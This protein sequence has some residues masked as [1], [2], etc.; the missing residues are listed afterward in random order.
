LRLSALVDNNGPRHPPSPSVF[1]K[2]TNGQEGYGETRSVDGANHVAVPFDSTQDRPATAK[3]LGNG[4]FNASS[5]AGFKGA[6]C[7]D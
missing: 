3:Q 4:V 1:A 6:V 2:A 5:I 7:E